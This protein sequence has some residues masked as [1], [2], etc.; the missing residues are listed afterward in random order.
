[1]IVRLIGLFFFCTTLAWGEH[2]K[3][4]II[5]RFEDAS[6]EADKNQTALDYGLIPKK[7]YRLTNSVLYSLDSNHSLGD[8]KKKLE[9]L[10]S[11]KYVSYNK[12]YRKQSY[13]PLFGYQ[14]YL[15][16]TGQTIRYVSGNANIDIGWPTALARYRKQINTYVAVLDS[17]FARDH[18]ELQGR[19]AISIAENTG[20]LGVDDDNN[21]YT[22]DVIGWDFID[23]DNDPY[24][25][26]GHGTQ[27]AAIIAGAKNE[28]GIQGISQDAY[29]RPIRV[30]NRDGTG[31]TSHLLEALQYIYENPGIR[32]INLSLGGPS[33]DRIL[34]EA[35]KAFE[36]DNQV[37]I[38]A[39]AGNGGD[40]G[41]GDDNDQKPY[42]PSSY[43]S[44][45]VISVASINSKGDLSSFS[46]YGQDSVDIA[47]PG[48]NIAV[49]TVERIPVLTQDADGQAWREEFWWLSSISKTWGRNLYGSNYWLESPRNYSGWSSLT[50]PALDLSQRHDPRMKIAL[51]FQLV[52]G[53]TSYLLISGDLTNWTM[54]EYFTSYAT[55]GQQ[56]F[57]FDISKWVGDD[58]V[59]VKF[60]FFPESNLEFFDV[61]PIRIEDVSPQAWSGTPYYDFARGTSFST[62]IVSG[63]ASL[64]MSHRPDLLASDV[65]KILIDSVQKLNKLSGKVKS[66]GIVRAEKALELADTYARRSSVAF[67]PFED[68]K[69][70]NDYKVTITDTYLTGREL[71]VGILEGVGFY[72]E[73]TQITLKANTSPGFV[74]QGWEEVGKG[75]VSQNETYSFTSEFKNYTFRAQFAEDLSD[76]DNDEFPNY[77]EVAY[78]T[79]INNS[80]SDGDE[81]NDFNEWSVIFHSSLLD[82][83][84]NDSDRIL[85]LRNALGQESSAEGNQSALQQA[86]A[87]GRTEG[88]QSVVSNPEA[89]DLVT[90]N[91]YDKMVEDM[92]GS[93]NVSPSN[94]TRD[95]FYLPNR[96]WLWTNS[97]TY[98]FFYDASSSNWVYFESGNEKPRFYHYGTKSWMDLE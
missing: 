86:K 50:S 65:K 73:G 63:V 51:D 62:P 33:Y 5:V 66:G 93:Q 71:T 76:P 15:D 14:W 28:V 98:P 12:I 90:K 43:D 55:G 87:A 88:Q 22:D 53:G 32:I 48:N 72:F 47:A 31:S 8:I 16:N 67:V 60:D 64:V 27:V 7:T 49:A 70:S 6:T 19:L 75:L 79:N 97:Q 54:L 58:S 24:D 35:F 96:G 92:I 84:G 23:N 18:Q 25:F 85:K 39:A 46:N 2:Q 1:M 61:G 78:G 29:I 9:K 80:N 4:E 3:G 20:T 74:F 37:L 82:L 42:Y 38:V 34:E 81:L 77:A 57:E 36:K 13:D 69:I 91:A 26:R 52:Y 21:N 10:S 17:G 95:W 40:D 83:N 45:S 94:Y 11:V 44:S 56:V 30:L 59:W 68:Q 89:Y 41:R